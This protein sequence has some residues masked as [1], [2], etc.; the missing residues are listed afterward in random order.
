MSGSLINVYNNAAFAM[1]RQAETMARLQ[2]QA[3]T[4]SRINRASDD[5]SAAYRILGLNSQQASLANYTDTLNAIV[6]SME[7][8][9]TLFAQIQSELTDTKARITQVLGG[10]YD[11]STRER[12]ADGINDIL[13]QVISFANTKHSGQYLFGGT[14]SA[15]APYVIE[16]DSQG[17]IT[18]VTYQGSFENRNVEAA[19]GVEASAFQVGEDV[20]RSDDRSDPQFVGSTGAANGTGTSSVTGFVWLTVTYDGSNYKMSIDDGDTWTTVPAGGNTNQAVTDSRTGKVLYVDST[21]INNTGTDMVCVPGTHDI[22]NTLIT[23]RDVFKNDRELPESQIQ[24]IRDNLMESLD[25]VSGLVTQTS[26][27]TGSKINFLNNLKQG[28]EDIK[29]NAETETTNIEEADITQIAIGLARSETLYQMSL[30]VV[31]KTM[32]MSLLDFIE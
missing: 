6:S 15:S 5:P 12:L 29:F 10:I 28:L 14:D 4:G 23:I 26:V 1:A 17:K 11:A 9:S 8:T 22:F 20:F 32:S 25:E 18:T 27:S 19:P 30:A 31:A 13:E 21:A 2:E 16:R 3:S 24:T 7:F